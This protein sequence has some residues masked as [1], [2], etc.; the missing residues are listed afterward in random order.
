MWWE[1]R[2][3]PRDIVVPI[4]QRW[5]VS[6]LGWLSGR[7][8]WWQEI[9][10]VLDCPHHGHC[11][12]LSWNLT[13][14]NIGRIVN[15]IM[16]GGLAM[17]WRYQDVSVLKFIEKLS[18]KMQQQQQLLCRPTSLV[19]QQLAGHHISISASNLSLFIK[20]IFTIDWVWPGCPWP[21]W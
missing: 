20:Q 2:L 18:G 16:A 17:R 14:W 21:G 19:C 11:S 13:V 3:T 8:Q 7:R 1:E 9:S 4:V 15:D 12:L 5:E 6:I 10:I